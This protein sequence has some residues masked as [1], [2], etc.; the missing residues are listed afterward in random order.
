MAGKEEFTLDDKELQEALDLYSTVT[1]S[2]MSIVINRK[3]KDICFHAGREI[4]KA[5]KSDINKHRPRKRKQEERH[6]LHFALLASGETRHGKVVR[7]QGIRKKVDEVLSARYGAVGYAQAIWMTLETH[8]GAKL[9]SKFAVDGVKG[10]KATPRRLVA[11]IETGNMEIDLRNGPMLGALKVGIK[12][13]TE[14][15]IKEANRRI[16]AN[17]RKFSGR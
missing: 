3:A 15:M 4:S 16:E 14:S 17:A 11:Y 13:G 12:K 9:K 7:G 2:D 5:K 10:V 1:T 6:R 8:F